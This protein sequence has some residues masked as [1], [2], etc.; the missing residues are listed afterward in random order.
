MLMTERTSRRSF[1]ASTD[2]KPVIT[3]LTAPD[4]ERPPGLDPLFERAS[5]VRF[6]W[7]AETLRQTL[8]G[9]HIM[10]VTDFRTE[11]LREA[12]PCADA[13]QWIHATSAGVDALMFP[14]LVNSEVTVTNAQGI[15]DRGIAEYVLC[16]ILMFAKDLPTSIRLQLQHQWKH[17][18]TE[19]A[20]GSRVLVVG[21]GSIGREIARLTSAIGLEVHGI[22]RRSRSDDP[23]F[24]AVH[25]NAALHDQL[26]LADFVVIAAPLTPATEK[27]FD[28]SA[29]KAM[30]STARLI[31]IG[32][33]PI[34]DT[35]A[36]VNALQNGDIAGVG[37]DVFEEEPLPS[38]HS[39]WAMDNAILTAHMAGDLIGWKAA[40]T[41]QFLENLANREKGEALFN[42]VDKAFGYVPNRR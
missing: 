32:R 23:D 10:M 19:K 17:R 14:E 29:F 18:D 2:N 38:D 6:A 16:T 5:E 15:F 24:V 22:A 3:V 12:W 7:D 8:P 25:D 1:M 41:E 11:A 33:G 13:L 26:G 27:L 4:E 35:Q 9:T 30:K 31:N 39:L 37:L 42:V 28:A 36:L 21:A 20:K 34:V 40:L